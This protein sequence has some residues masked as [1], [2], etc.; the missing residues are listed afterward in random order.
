MQENLFTRRMSN[1]HASCSSGAGPANQLFRSAKGL[2]RS[3]PKS[4]RVCALDAAALDGMYAAA[5]VAQHSIPTGTHLATQMLSSSHGHSVSTLYTLGDAT[6]S[7]ASAAQ[8][9]AQDDGWLAPITRTL[10]YTLQQIQTGLDQ[11]HVPYSYGWAI[12]GLTVATKIATFP[13]T[14]IQVESALQVQKLKPT[15]DAIKAQY[16]D[17]KKAIQRE[18]TALYEA[19]GVNP[20]AGCLPTLAT[21]PVF[22]GLYR[23]LSNVSQ[24]GL[25]TEGFYWIPS[26]SGPASLADQRAGAGTAWLLP[27]VN[28]APPIGWE[29]AS[30]YLVLPVLL[31]V[32][33]FASSAIISP[34]NKDDEQSNSWF[35]K[36]LL[37]FVPFMVG[38][39]ALNLPAGLGL[40]YFSNTMITSGIQIWLRK[41]GGASAFEW[42]Q[43]IGLNQARR[44]GEIA[45]MQALMAFA[46]AEAEAAAALGDGSAE[47]AQQMLPMA[48]AEGGAAL[49]ASNGNGAPAPS[50]GVQ[51]GPQAALQI[52]GPMRAKRRRR[53]EPEAQTTA[54]ASA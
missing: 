1:A 54:T 10:D 37:V 24:A 25:L 30:K 21:I 19:S 5:T 42:Q 46:V 49:E 26:L 48:Q 53:T 14:K 4:F 2:R 9:V 22:W 20:A 38:W 41:L 52:A 8:A 31:V 27:L 45:D 18:T 7:Q 16:G 29:E 12:I 23:T 43:E 47:T 32:A 17:D 3:P 13:F 28:G 40:Y 39:F 11:L 51:S 44:S 33:Q 34:V 15:I 50:E 6:V 36:A 35:N